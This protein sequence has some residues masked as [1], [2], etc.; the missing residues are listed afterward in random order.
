MKVIDAYSL[1]L[2]KEPELV[3]LVRDLHKMG[4]SYLMEF[5]K[6]WNNEII[7]QFYASYHHERDSTGVIDI[8]HW[9][10]ED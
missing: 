7:Y 6:H 3:Q 9:T 1:G 4:P 2:F 8:I 10:T 5:R